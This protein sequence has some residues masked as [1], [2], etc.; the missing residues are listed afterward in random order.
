MTHSE[1]AVPMHSLR[2][3]V[4]LAGLILLGA[5]G[6]LADEVSDAAARARL[7][8]AW[9]SFQ[10]G[11]D[12][13]RDSLVNPEHFP[14][15]ATDRNL[16]EGHRYLLGHLGRLIEQEMRLD[17]RF[18]EFHRSVDML[19]KHT[20][21]NPDAIYLKAPIDGIG[22]YRV[23]G[24]V[25]DTAEWSDSTRI[26]AR[27]KAPRLVTFQTTTGVPGDTGR[28]D[29]MGLCRTQTLDFVN[30]FDLEIDADGRFELW[31][32]PER[33]DGVNGNYLTSRKTMTCATTKKTE[34]REATALAVREIFSDW[35]HEQPLELEIVRIDAEGAARPPID[36]EWMATRLETISGKVR[37]HIRFWSLLMEF[38]LEI[39]RDAN[40]DGRRNLPV[41]GM[42]DAAPPFTAGGAAGAQQLYASGVFELE[43]DQALIVRVEAPVEPHYMGFQLNN[44]WM[45]GPDQQN[46][47]S[48]LTAHQNPIG[49]D[50]ARYYVIAHRDPGVVGWV[51]TT[52]LAHGFQAMRFVFRNPPATEDLP[53]ISTQ[54]VTTDQVAASLPE[55]TP[56]IDAEAR[57]REVAVRQAHIKLRY[58]G[59]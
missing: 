19:R 2:V 31:I 56:R 40:G 37:N 41:N 34:L 10:Q 15:V 7:D 16:A 8:A 53:R 54:L 33:P 55:G 25:A 28:L 5:G 23:R 29:E 9:T 4:S 59:Y 43:L 46:Y 21:E 42:N 17:P 35:E 50:G 48:S 30:S 22:V 26:G 24:R 51:D 32:A 38:P 52:G 14:P 45:E 49:P 58:P 44:H 12:E 36:A 27:S 57:R 3:L 6:A 20:G 39:R 47:V 11:L 1:E 18:P 13:A